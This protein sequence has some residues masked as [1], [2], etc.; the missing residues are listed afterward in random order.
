MFNMS[1]KRASSSHLCSQSPTMEEVSIVRFSRATLSLCI[2]VTLSCAACGWT[3]DD[4]PPY[5]DFGVGGEE[6]DP[7]DQSEE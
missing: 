2:F 1:V 5:P 6:A 4:P 3:L 7:N